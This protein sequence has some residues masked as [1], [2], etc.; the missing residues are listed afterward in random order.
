MLREV[1]RGKKDER[2]TK[3]HCIPTI[4]Q[5]RWQTIYLYYNQKMISKKYSPVNMFMRATAQW[6]RNKP[7]RSS[8]GEK[9]DDPGKVGT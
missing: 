3:M 4:N 9:L 8:T 6:R 2:G 1:Q 7:E 5:A